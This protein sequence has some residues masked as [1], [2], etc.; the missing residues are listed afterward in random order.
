M[1]Q[2]R[3]P[4]YRH[5]ETDLHV[6]AKRHGDSEVLPRNLIRTFANKVSIFPGL[7]MSLCKKRVQLL[8]WTSITRPRQYENNTTDATSS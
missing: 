3:Q 2:K 6:I 1:A 4:Y 8:W 7:L 5:L